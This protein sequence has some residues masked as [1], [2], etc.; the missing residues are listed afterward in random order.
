M[1][2]SL[3]NPLLCGGQ[4]IYFDDPRD[5][6]WEYMPDLRRWEVLPPGLVQARIDP[7]VVELPGGGFWI[8][9]DGNSEIYRGGIFDNETAPG[10]LP[11]TGTPCA[12]QVDDDLTFFGTGDLNDE[13]YTYYR[14]SARTG[15][16]DVLTNMPLS[17]DG[18]MCGAATNEVIMILN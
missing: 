16:F 9:S 12:V 5:Q 14:Y 7:A 8:I 6:C 18:A 2:T 10:P 11:F 4:Y 3:G 1:R 15:D 17:A 13:T